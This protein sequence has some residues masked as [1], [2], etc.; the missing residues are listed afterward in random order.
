MLT[1]IVTRGIGIRA[2]QLRRKEQLPL[3]SPMKIMKAGD[4]YVQKR[5]ALMPGMQGQNSD[6]DTRDT[7]LTNFP[8]FCPKCKQETLVNMKE[9]NT[10][11]IKGPDA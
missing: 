7:T 4:I 8:L 6:A 5:M 11:I 10:E 2:L 9:L 1:M 3:F